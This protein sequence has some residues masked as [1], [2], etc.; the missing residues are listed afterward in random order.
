MNKNINDDY[1]YKNYL[2]EIL[3]KYI[4]FMLSFVKEEIIKEKGLI[5]VRYNPISL[6]SVAQKKRNTRLI[7]CS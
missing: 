5:K 3:R 7:F 1:E 4:R 2:S 6:T